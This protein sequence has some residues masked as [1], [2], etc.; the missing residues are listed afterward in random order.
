MCGRQK[1]KERLQSRL[2]ETVPRGELDDA[3]AEI[4]RMKT[5]LDQL[6][7]RLLAAP[8]QVD[9][10][11]LRAEADALRDQLKVKRRTRAPKEWEGP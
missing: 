8:S 7:A 1:E 9:V 5:E 6:Q 3:K 2:L 4:S 10:D 11:S